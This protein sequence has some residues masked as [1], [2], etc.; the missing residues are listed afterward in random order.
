MGRNPVFAIG[1]LLSP[2][3]QVQT[4]HFHPPFRRKF[5]G[6]GHH[7][8]PYQIKGINRYLLASLIVTSY[9]CTIR[10]A[11]R[12]TLHFGLLLFKMLS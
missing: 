12:G 10:P 4:M 9:D 6:P 11:E 1:S 8:A 2:Q 7:E 5:I 3:F